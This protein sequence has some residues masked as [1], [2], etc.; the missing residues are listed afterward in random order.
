MEMIYFST[1]VILILTIFS[2]KNMKKK[3]IWRKRKKKG[4]LGEKEAKPFLK[5]KGYKILDYQYELKYYFY[6]NESKI[7][8]KIRPDYIVK[9]GFKKY[10]AE[11]KTGIT[12]TNPHN[13]ATR[14]QL[15]EYYFAGD[16]DGILLVDMENKRIKT[17]LFKN[18]RLE[19][20]KKINEILIIL[21]IL[22]SILFV[23]AIKWKK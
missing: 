11:V 1:G 15:L 4:M 14:R 9:K 19:K 12:V 17:I 16:F 6:A 3:Y 13:K 20:T 18:I 8:V 22:M 23:G 7:K 10:I 2:I 21:L 5:S